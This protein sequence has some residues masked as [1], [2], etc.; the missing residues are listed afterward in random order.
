MS[1]AARALSL[2]IAIGLSLLLLVFPFLLGS[3]LGAREH[4]ALTLLLL[5]ISGAFVHGFGYEPQRRAWR[6]LFH[7]LTAWSLVCVGLAPFLVRVVG[8]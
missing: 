8:M 7:P 2:T 1:R 6:V 5:G 3:E 4:V